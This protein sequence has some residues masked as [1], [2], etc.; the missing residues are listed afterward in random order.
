MLVG[1]VAMLILLVVVALSPMAI[2]PKAAQAARTWTVIA[3]GGTR[4]ASVVANAFFPRTIEVAVGDTVAWKFEGFHQ[5]AFLGGTPMPPLTVQDGNKMYVNPQVAFPAGGRRYDG[6]GYHNSGLPPEDPQGMMKFGYAL[7]FTKEGTYAYV[8]IVHGPAMAGTVVV[9]ARA[10][11]SPAAALRRA[12]QEQ[13]ASVR[14]GQKAWT[15]WRTEREGATVVVPLIGDARQGFSVFRFSPRPLVVPVG[16]TV[17]W[18]MRDP[19]EIHTVTF[20]GPGKPPLF[21]M[22]EPQPQGPP[23]LLINPQV[24]AAT[25][26]RSYDGMGFVNSG[27]LYPP[28]APPNLPKSHSLTFT[29]PGKYVYVCVTHADLGMYGQIIVK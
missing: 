24:A 15:A 18:V 17:K 20:A 16:T 28:G 29:K 3:G 4:D 8:C 27:I 7:T 22:P 12:R 6:M 14:A 23:R 1:K 10:A 5:I 2:A 25:P 11:G 9:K 13:A 26:H 21:V 19:F